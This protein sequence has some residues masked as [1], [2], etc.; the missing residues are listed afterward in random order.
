MIYV[1]FRQ[2]DDSGDDFEAPALP[3]GFVQERQDPD[4]ICL[5][6]SEDEQCEHFYVECPELKLV[7]GEVKRA[8]R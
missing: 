2:A 3:V 5:A 8:R 7:G 1:I 6:L 4:E